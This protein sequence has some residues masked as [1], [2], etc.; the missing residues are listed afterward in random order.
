MVIPANETTLRSYLSFFFGQQFSLLG[1]SIVQFAIVWW[2]NLETAST[3]YLSLAAFVGFV[4]MVILGF[5]TG[6]FADRFNRKTIIALADF[7]QAFAT[8]VLIIFFLLDWA[9]IFAVLVILTFR[10]VCQAFHA[11]TVNAIVP[12]MVPQNKL[13][14]INSLEYVLNG[15]VNVAGPLIASILLA[16]FG[17]E[18]ILW[19]DPATFLVAFT[20]LLLTKIPS[21]RESHQKTSFKED[22]TQGFAFIRSARG[23]LPLILVATV[24]NF[25]VMPISTLLPYFVKFVHLGAASDLAM[26][27]AVIQGGLLAGGLFML[28]NKGFTKKIPA[29]VISILVSLIGYAIVSFTPLGLFW[30][31]AVAGLVFSLPIPVGNISVRTMIQTAVPLKIQGRVSSV[32]MSLASLASPLGMIISGVLANYVGTAN[33]FLGSALLGILVLVPSWFLTDIRHV[34]DM[35]ANI[36][37]DSPSAMGDYTSTE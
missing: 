35:E 3:L 21:V 16:F 26:V 24:L 15:A 27:E 28:T 34:G 18:Q 14:R 22:F 6:V 20:I 8:V 9:S 36:G 17:V 2:I 37:T 29:F 7:A 32:I 30:F 10:G 19:I 4:P 1:S 33:L 5:F 11:P 25:L 31:M 12:S 23:L 13:S